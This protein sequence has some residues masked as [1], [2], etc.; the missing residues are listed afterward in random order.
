MIP[1]VER[2]EVIK[3]AGSLNSQVAKDE[4]NF[5]VLTDKNG[6]Q[7]FNPNLIKDE[8]AD[9]LA[10]SSEDEALSPNSKKESW[11]DKAYA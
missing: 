1:N 3:K 9:D 5:P 8:T 10:G 4:Q 6:W 2:S 7:V 11:R